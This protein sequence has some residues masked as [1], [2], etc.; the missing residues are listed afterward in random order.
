[1]A[2]DDIELLMGLL[3]FALVCLVGVYLCALDS[4]SLASTEQ[5]APPLSTVDRIRS[6]GDGGGG[7]SDGGV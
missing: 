4:L 1:M 2:D 3:L 7:G 5:E 6:D